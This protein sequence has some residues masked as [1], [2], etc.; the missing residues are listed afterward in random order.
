MSEANAETELYILAFDGP[1]GV[2]YD[3]VIEAFSPEEAL[4]IAW[5]D[6]VQNKYVLLSERTNPASEYRFW[7]PQLIERMKGV[8]G[9]R[10]PLSPS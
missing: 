10:T 4:D 8:S 1:E 9:V 7:P 5:Q 3:V 6:A 2:L